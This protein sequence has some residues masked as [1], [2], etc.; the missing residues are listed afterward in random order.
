M[1]EDLL[2][3]I[4]QELYGRME[5]L[6]P[7]LEECDRLRADLRALEA[8]PEL[9][10]AVDIINL[11]SPVAFESPVALEVATESPYEPEPSAAE[12]ESSAA[13]TVDPDPS[14]TVLRFPGNRKPVRT[15]AVSPQDAR[16]I[17]TLFQP[18]SVPASVPASEPVVS[19][20]VARLMLAPRRPALERSGIPRV[21]ALV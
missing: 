21:G 6:Y 16:P 5:E 20:K 12:P 13:L 8:V 3:R 7:A 10:A 19:P 17:S 15:A 2:S 1:V 9:P 11:E 14:G 4:E 18:A